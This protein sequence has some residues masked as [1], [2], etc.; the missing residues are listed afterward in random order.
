MNTPLPAAGSAGAWLL[1]SRPATL[2]AAVVPVF[3]GAA[4]AQTQGGFR[5]GPSLVCL[6]CAIFI[7][8][9]TNFANDVFDFE[10]GADTAERLGPVRAVQAGLL[11]PSQVRRGMGIAFGLTALCALYLA[12]IGGWP[13]LGLGALAIASGIAYTGG[14]YPLGYHGLGDLFVII[15]FGFVAVAG[16]AYA[17]LLTVPE[18]AWW[19]AIPVGFLATAI[20]VVNNLRD[21]PT[22]AASGKRTLAVR[23]GRRGALLEYGTLLVVSYAIP[24]V[25]HARGI[26]GPWIYLPWLTAPMALRLGLQILRRQGRELNA[27]LVATARLLFIFGLTLTVGILLS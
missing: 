22:D 12:A 10:K 6:A 4:C 11:T 16:T 14:P 1:A 7:Q 24:G 17:N 25:L 23:F 18:I 5:L 3:V 15:F 21:L 2:A 20:L 8:I 27:V 26:A 19:A 9:G 13:L